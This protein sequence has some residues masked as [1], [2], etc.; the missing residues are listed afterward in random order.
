M[1]R[2]LA[3]LSLLFI[4]AQPR[5]DSVFPSTGSV[6]GG[7]T[8]VIHGS[9]FD[10]TCPPA[11]D[12]CGR[13]SVGFGA[14]SATSFRV[15]DKETIET[16]T[17]PSF[18][19]STSVGVSLPTGAAFLP[20]AFTFTGD[21]SDAFERILLP[22]FTP[23]VNGSFGSRF[24]TSF[25]MWNIAGADIPAFGLAMAPCGCIPL[26][27]PPPP[28]PRLTVL[29]ARQNAP[30]YLFEPVG[31]PGYFAFVPRGAF[32]RIA[33]SLRVADVSRQD[34]SF[35]TRIPL[36]PERDFRSDFIALVDIPMA[37][38]FRTLLRVYSIDPETSVHLRVIRYDSTRIYSE[39]DI[40]LRDP[41]DMFHPGYAQ[42]SDFGNVPP[43]N[44][45]I[46]IEP[47]QGKRV[48]ALVSITNNETQQ[49]TVVSPH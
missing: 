42:I 23:P 4:F 40:D 3:I 31:D 5:I 49:I 20:N 45:R 30:E 22:I 12:P 6:T 2:L 19:G 29:K 25:S 1:I 9:G 35:G 14:I 32:D 15:I 24:Y 18:P 38:R 11:P 17:P 27:P 13:T 33:A 28:G 21:V 46:E 43:D 37:P 26:V 41:I 47:R 16:L 39:M 34:Q 7:T 8:V 36:A 48:W 44:V 10:L